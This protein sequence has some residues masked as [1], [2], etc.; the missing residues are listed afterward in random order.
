ML[1]LKSRF[2]CLLLDEHGAF[3]EQVWPGEPGGTMSLVPSETGDG[4]F[5]AT[6]QFYSP[7]DS[8]QARIVRAAPRPG[9]GWAVATLARLPHVHRFDVLRRGGVS[10]MIACTICSGRDYKDDWSHP[11]KVYACAL[12]DDLSAAGQAHPLAFETLSE[13]MLKNHGYLRC[14]KNGAPAALVTCESGVYRYTPPAAPGGAWEVEHLLEEPVSDVCLVDFDGDGVEEADFLA[15][16][17]ANLR[18]FG[19]E[20]GKMNRS[21]LDIGGGMLVV[22]NF[23]LCA[24]TRH[25]RRPSFTGAAGPKTADSLYLRFVAAVKDTGVTSVQTGRFGADM[26]VSIENDGPVTVILDTDE[27]MKRPGKV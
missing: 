18:I 8:K 5:L 4:S 10:Y 14:H 12:P 13:G 23:T 11:G 6:W 1:I 17:A 25:G 24:D 9:G 19:D 22:S 27:I 3:V 21:L 15:E 7:N 16:K 26:L 2:L 20:Q